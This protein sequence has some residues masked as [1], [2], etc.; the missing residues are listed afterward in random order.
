MFGPMTKKKQLLSEE[1]ALEILKKGSSGVL[2][3]ITEE[4]YPYGVPMSYAYEDGKLYFH[5]AKIGLRMECVKQCDKACFSVIAQDD[6]IPVDYTTNFRSVIA[7]GKIRI[8]E[9]DA[10]RRDAIIKIGKKYFPDDVVEHLNSVID[11]FYAPMQIF[12]M[13]VEQLTGKQAEGLVGK[14]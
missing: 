1:A 2:S 12:I 5:G 9:D 3:L 11:Q 8:S 10:E 7:F 14:P 13:D 4:G 6:V